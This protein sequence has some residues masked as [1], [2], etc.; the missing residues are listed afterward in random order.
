MG[1]HAPRV[2]K[3]CCEPCGSRRGGGSRARADARVERHRERGDCAERE[4]EDAPPQRPSSCA[5]TR[6]TCAVCSRRHR[7]SLSQAASAGASDRCGFDELGTGDRRWDGAAAAS[8]GL[9]SSVQPT[10]WSAGGLNVVRTEYEKTAKIATAATDVGDTL[11][12]HVHSENVGP[13]VLVVEDDPEIAALMRDYLEADGFRVDI[14][15]T[16]S[17]RPRPADGARLCAT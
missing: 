16:R 5:A 1:A 12:V 4:G 6:A 2:G 11:P 17:R 8:T 10:S 14:A 3:F 13:L 9:P 15:P 7:F